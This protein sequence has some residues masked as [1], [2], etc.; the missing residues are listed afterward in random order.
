M[1]F[2]VCVCLLPTTEIAVTIQR[3]SHIRLFFTIDTVAIRDA[4]FKRLDLKVRLN[5]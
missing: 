5:V 4:E 3:S 1:F 2:L